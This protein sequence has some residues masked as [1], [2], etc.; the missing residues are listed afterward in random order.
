MSLEEHERSTTTL[1]TDFKAV[2]ALATGR[3]GVV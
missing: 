3:E 2:V 1:R